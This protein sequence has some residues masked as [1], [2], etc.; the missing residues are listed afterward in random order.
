MDI[1]QITLNSEEDVK[2]HLI[3]PL[4]NSLGFK[5]ELQFEGSFSIRLGRNVTRTENSMRGRYDI[6]VKYQGRNLCIFEAKSSDQSLSD[7]DRDQAISYARLVHPMCPVAIL[8]NGYE[9]RIFDVITKDLINQNVVN[10]T[11]G[12]HLAVDLDVEIQLRNEALLH[13]IGLSKSNFSTFCELQRTVEMQQLIGTEADRTIKKYIP[14]L[15]VKRNDLDS[16]YLSFVNQQLKNTFA[17]IGPSG[18]GKTN[19]MCY[20]ANLLTNLDSN[21]F[22]LFYTGMDLGKSLIEC[23]A[24]DFNM[25]FSSEHSNIQLLKNISSLLSR[26]DSELIIFVDAIDEWT[27]NSGRELDYFI[28]TIN[29]LNAPIKLAVSCKISA[30][31][32]YKWRN[33]NPSILV[34]NL[35]SPLLPYSNEEDQD[36]GNVLPE[37]MFLNKFSSIELEEASKKY[38]ESYHV[39][40]LNQPT[41]KA[42]INDPFMLRLISE[43]Y[44]QND[45]PLDIREERV[46]L[47]YI[48]KKQAVISDSHLR[49]KLSRIAS[50]IL[51]LSNS[52]VFESDLVTENY[53]ELEPLI[54]H[55]LLQKFQDQH[56]RTRISFYFNPLRDYMVA[57]DVLKLDTLI[58]ADFVQQSKTLMSNPI[59]QSVLSWYY[60]YATYEQRLHLV[61]MREFRAI[62]FLQAYK[63][64]IRRNTPKLINQMEPFTTAD[65]GLNVYFEALEV[66]E[67]GFS[68]LEENASQLTTYDSKIP[69]SKECPI[70]RFASTNFMNTEP[71]DAAFLFCKNQLE[72]IV[73]KGKLNEDFVVPLLTEKL[74]ALVYVYQKQFQLDMI[75][76][77]FSKL[78]I[79]V[80]YVG[81]RL[82]KL[83][84][85][86]LATEEVLLSGGDINKVTKREEEL[87][88]QSVPLPY[89]ISKYMFGIGNES[90]PLR[91]LELYITQLRAEGIESISP[92]LPSVDYELLGV[93]MIEDLYSPDR[94]KEVIA[95]FCEYFLTVLR[96]VISNNFPAYE[97]TMLPHGT[98]LEVNYDESQ[99]WPL[100]ELW[101]NNGTED[102]TKIT[103]DNKFQH[104][105]SDNIVIKSSTF[106]NLIQGNN[107]T[108]PS[109]RAS[110]YTPLR[111]RVYEEI[112]ERLNH[113][114]INRQ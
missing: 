85:H 94:K 52:S 9:T 102:N 31:A 45:I 79:P 15:Y 12:F 11:G 44:E 75:N 100:C 50:R 40:E 43:V 4:L 107:L 20:T 65:I 101:C 106:S 112:K 19:W 22:S 62:R 16:A 80:D 7:S 81:Q 82:H 24:N 88:S 58:L 2:V 26:D 17:L 1:K 51:E 92:V 47:A 78:P 110:Q 39:T 37:P 27:D 108:Y 103:F 5:E 61:Q 109:L 41:V 99:H 60:K 35:F 29:R 66:Q 105:L 48:E 72:E 38:S 91:E 28:N 54:H 96:T 67:F 113:V 73:K 95:R 63:D 84:A 89:P 70:I 98:K 69:R 74:Y 10:G 36:Q 71:E 83:K 55:G 23:I 97:E 64:L 30:W 42:I 90:F 46:F 13:F 3:I 56:G 49:V 53:Q 18:A 8:S 6:L 32:N 93:S 21:K 104:R 25:S 111:A 87:L 59:G 33:G 57:M 76:P 114:L 14:L 86:M 77:L 34:M 68:I